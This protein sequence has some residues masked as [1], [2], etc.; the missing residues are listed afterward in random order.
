MGTNTRQTYTLPLVCGIHCYG[1]TATTID[2]FAQ[3][4]DT[5]NLAL[6]L[7]EGI[8]S[9]FNGK[10]CCGYALENNIDDVGYFKHLQ[11]MLSDEYS[12]IKGEENKLKTTMK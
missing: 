3:Y 10:Y 4:T 6:V 12:F 9:S 8:Q 2:V 1:C 5:L 11:T 7:P